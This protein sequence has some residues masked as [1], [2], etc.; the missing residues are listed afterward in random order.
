MRFLIQIPQLIYGGAEKVLVSF[1]N[2][3]AARGHSVEVLEIYEK[4]YLKPQFDS[5][6]TFHAI[7]SQEYTKKYYMSL[8]QI[9]TAHGTEKLAGCAKLAFSKLVGY[10]RFAEKLAAKHYAGRDF[11]VAINYLEGESPE[12]L[13]KHIHAKKYIQW[14]HTDVAHIDCPE[15]TD[16]LI[17]RFARMDAIICVAETARQSFADRYPQLAGKVHVLYNFFDTDAVLKAAAAPFS[18]PGGAPVL[19]SVGR[20]TAPKQYLRFL[21]VLAR[22]R[23]DGFPFRWYVLGTGAQLEEIQR[24]TEQLG[25]TERVHLEGLTDNPYRYMK[26]CDLFVLPSGWE[27]FP[28]VTVEAKIV[29]CPVLATDVSGI[30]EQ[31]VHGETGWIVA[32]D[33][34]A[35]Y[36][37]L[38]HLLLH[39]ELRA[40][41]QSNAGMERICDNG[42]KYREFM[43]ICGEE[44]I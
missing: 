16:R 30:R 32:N 28:T 18:F 26:N 38:K 2:E 33:E 3:L 42:E 43:Q 9:R 1:A 5:R 14:Y 22:L 15:N 17:P 41:L 40:K 29:G 31:L 25:L 8:Q 24:K 23:D 11:D 6:V 13:Q 12:F 35:I 34:T 36:E 27:G 39:P 37:G 4:G 19:L 21:D 44:S 7:C 10:R 20:M